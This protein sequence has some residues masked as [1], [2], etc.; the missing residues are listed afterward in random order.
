VHAAADGGHL[1]VLVWA[2]VHGCEW[3]EDAVRE[4][5]EIGGHLE[6]LRWLDDLQDAT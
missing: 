3:V 4:L 5:A 6:I 1:G 2:R